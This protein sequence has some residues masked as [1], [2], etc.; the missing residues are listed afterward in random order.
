VVEK[1]KQEAPSNS[2]GFQSVDE[3]V[4]AK[5]ETNLRNAPTTEGSEVI[6]KLKNGEYVRR[7]GIHSNGWSKL[8][9]N[10]TIVYA[11]TSYLTP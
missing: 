10:G 4:T 8:E 6:Y 9:Y 11:I 3:Q 7:I 1:P 5:E 2:D